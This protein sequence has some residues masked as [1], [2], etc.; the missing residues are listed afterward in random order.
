MADSAVIS[1]E[2]LIS[3]NFDSRFVVNSQPSLIFSVPLSEVIIKLSDECW[4][5]VIRSRICTTELVIPAA[6]RRTSFATM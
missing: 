3:E 5:S 4:I 6:R 2:V 1:E